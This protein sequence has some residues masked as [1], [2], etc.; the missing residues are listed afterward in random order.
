MILEFMATLPP[1]QRATF[2]LRFYR[3]MTFE[4]IARATGRAVPTVKTNY[5]Q[6]VAKLRQF[7]LERELL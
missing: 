7:A 6:A 2:E 4:E 1:Q 5:R 3:G